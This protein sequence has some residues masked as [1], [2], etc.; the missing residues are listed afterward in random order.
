MW[1]YKKIKLQ[2]PDKFLIIGLSLGLVFCLYGIQWGW[3]E[4]WH[5]DQMALRSLFHEGKL[6]LNPNYFAK[7]PFHTYLNLLLSRAPVY[8]VGTIFLDL[9]RDSLR[10]IELIWSRMLTVLMFLG[11]IILVFCIT[12]RFFGLFAARIISVIFATSAGFIAFSHFLTAD[13]PMLFW[14]LLAFY[15]IQNVLFSG[16]ISDYILVYRFSRI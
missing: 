6:P 5:P 8:I 11:A 7:P 1:K 13:I 2:K 14:M 16:K 10:P 4:T 15:F 9:P 3:V 12:K